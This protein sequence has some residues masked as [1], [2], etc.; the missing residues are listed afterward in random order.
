MLGDIPTAI[1]LMLKE[2]SR[3]DLLKRLDPP[4][5]GKGG[6]SF[7]DL[8]PLAFELLVAIDGATQGSIELGRTLQCIWEDSRGKG[9]FSWHL[10]IT[11]DSLSLFICMEGAAVLVKAVLGNRSAPEAM[12]LEAKDDEQCT[13]LHWATLQDH[14]EVVQARKQLLRHLVVSVLARIMQR[15]ILLVSF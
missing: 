2:C 4:L 13:P 11:D 7:H 12:K 10:G 8:L 1:A 15:S 14:G 9:L 6:R 3:A 5:K